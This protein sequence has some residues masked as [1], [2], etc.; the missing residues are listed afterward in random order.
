MGE[1]SKSLRMKHSQDRGGRWQGR[2]EVTMFTGIL[3]RWT[4]PHV[5]KLLGRQMEC[6]HQ[7]FPLITRGHWRRTINKSVQATLG[8]FCKRRGTDQT[9]W[10]PPQDLSCIQDSHFHPD[11]KLNQSHI[12]NLVLIMKAF[13]S[14]SLCSAGC[15][16][17]AQT[18]IY[19]L[20][21]Y[22]ESMYFRNTE[23]ADKSQ[24]QKTQDESRHFM[25]IFHLKKLIWWI[26]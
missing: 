20:Q 5:G 4:D 18:T 6:R 16:D 2:D 3:C 24:F 13:A 23:T 1:V 14:H 22:F 26:S 21:S 9:F 15:T 25:S 12:L 19:L 8:A 17:Q 7:D 10:G 11:I